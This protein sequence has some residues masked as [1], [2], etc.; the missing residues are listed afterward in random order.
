MSCKKK[1]RIYKSKFKLIKWKKKVERRVEMFQR[2][3]DKK[4]LLDHQQKMK[5]EY[6][7]QIY[8]SIQSWFYFIQTSVNSIFNY[9]QD[10]SKASV[11]DDEVISNDDCESPVS[12]GDEMERDE[13][14]DLDISRDADD[15]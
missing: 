2:K 13:E 7:N 10:V 8:D 4:S 9:Y 1:K 5:D 11:T 6:V 14:D 3:G 12:I 15:D